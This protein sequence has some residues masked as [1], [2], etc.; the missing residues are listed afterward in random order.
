MTRASL[1]TTWLA[2]ILLLLFS[3]LSPALAL[4]ATDPAIVPADPLAASRQLVVVET[5][6]WEATRGVLK[7]YQRA[8]QD[9]PWSQ[10][11]E[12]IP[13]NVGRKGL[14]WSEGFT[15]ESK[16]AGPTKREGDRK[17]PA[18][19]FA[20]TSAFA[21]DPAELATSM[22]VLSAD[23]SLVC[24]DDPK[25][26]LYNRVVRLDPSIQKDWSSQENM[27]RKDHQ[28]R[29]GLVVDHNH[30]GAL[31]EGGSCIFLHIWEAPELAT[32]GCTS[33]S[34]EN[35]VSLINWLDPAAKPLLLQ[36]TSPARSVFAARWKIQ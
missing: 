28:Y 29:Y 1:F 23:A 18:G 4:T 15:L 8:S 6:H 10:V 26:S 14:A 30:E 2:A 35:L 16:P 3:P 17:A 5:P 20:L 24:V 31:P 12:A 7:R 27:R 33:M 21:Y 36:M 25:S 9:A 22:P 11:G 32:T 19:L 13:V 34:A